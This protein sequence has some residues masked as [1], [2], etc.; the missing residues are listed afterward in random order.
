MSLLRLAFI[1]A[2]LSPFSAFAHDD[3]KPAD[4]Q[5]VER[6]W[7]IVHRAY[8]PT[9]KAA[10]ELGKTLEDLGRNVEIK[11]GRLS[12]CEDDK[13]GQYV[14]VTFDP[15]ASP[16]RVDLEIPGDAKLF[17]GIYRIDGDVLS[18][19]ISTGKNR[20]ESFQIGKECVLLILKEVPKK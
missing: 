4:N 11:G 20:A 3:D 9:T 17:R 12:S 6:A 1:A 15:G 16:Q 5:Q 18:I 2:L 14:T 19:S 13:L 8:N 7:R 10:A